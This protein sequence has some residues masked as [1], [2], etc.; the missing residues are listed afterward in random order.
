[1]GIM[2]VARAADFIQY[3]GLR[4]SRVEGRVQR[5]LNSVPDL[6]PGKPAIEKVPGKQASFASGECVVIRRRGPRSRQPERAQA[7]R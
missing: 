2:N 6:W 5:S 3:R 7:Q 4:R 1:M